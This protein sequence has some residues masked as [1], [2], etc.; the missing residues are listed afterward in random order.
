MTDTET[1]LLVLWDVDGTLIYNGG[2]S[3]EAYACGFQLL[4]GYFP[5]EPVVT[6]G[7]TDSAIM[8]ALFERHGLVLTPDL[9]AR[10]REVM[11]TALESLVPQLRERGHAMPGARD[12]IDALAQDNTLV[13]S[14]LTGNVPQ[15]AFRKTATFGLHAGLDFEIGGYG[16]DSEHRP[17]LVAAARRK[18]AAKYGIEFTPATT[19]LIGDTPRDVEAGRLGGA[20]VVGVC[21]GKFDAETLT[22]LGADV[23]LPDLRDTEKVVAAVLSARRQ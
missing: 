4:T 10:T 17:E 8:R 23:V 6:D 7:M 1:S 12:A 9:A 5:T 13:Q 2:V 21:T 15:N 3:K 11:P 16:S 14:V 18:A 19:V 22:G 20:Y